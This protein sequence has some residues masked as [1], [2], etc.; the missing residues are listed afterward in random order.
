VYADGGDRAGRDSLMLASL[1]AGIAFSNSSVTLIHGMS[2][3]IGGNFHVAHG[4]SNAMLLPTITEFSIAGAPERYAEISRVLGASRP[5]ASDVTAAR[6]LVDWLRQL[7]AD[8]AVP[9]PASYGIDRSVWD[10]LIPTMA[11]QAIASG[12]PANNPVV[13]SR[14]Q[15]EDLYARV[16]DARPL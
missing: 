6:R 15:V 13:P 9:T 2:R 7:C 14:E 8:L 11:Q 1:Q 5:N 3:P 12:S 16:F 4:L 10:A